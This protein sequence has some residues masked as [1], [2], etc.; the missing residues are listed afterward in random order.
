[1]LEVKDGVALAAVRTE[2]AE[3]ARRARCPSGLIVCDVHSRRG[4]PRQRRRAPRVPRVIEDA[5]VGEMPGHARQRRA[6]SATAGAGPPV[7][8]PLITWG[9]TLRSV[10]IGV[11]RW[12]RPE[13]LCPNW[14]FPIT[15]RLLTSPLH[16]PCPLLNN[17][18]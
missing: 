15:P 13:A 16:I 7:S 8:L 3:Q 11:P 1:M 17:R 4:Q 18:G 12:F 2:G 6:A 10:C 5:I 9:G 14:R